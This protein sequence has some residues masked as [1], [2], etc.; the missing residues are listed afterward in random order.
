MPRRGPIRTN[1]W[2]LYLTGGESDGSTAITSDFPSLEDALAHGHRRK[3]QDVAVRLHVGERAKHFVGDFHAGNVTVVTYS[4]H[5]DA[6]LAGTGQVVGKRA[7]GFPNGLADQ[8]FLELDSKR[9]AL[10]PQGLEFLFSQHCLEC[11]WLEAMA[12]RLLA[13]PC[14]LPRHRLELESPDQVRR[15][16]P[17]A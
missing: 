1:A 4:N 2:P 3:R 6:R 17:P 9:L 14:I 11:R 15:M 8:P 12:Y 7:D 10:Q 16:H 13:V 5:Y